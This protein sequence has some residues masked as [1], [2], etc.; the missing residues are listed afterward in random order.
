MQNSP[1]QDCLQHHPTS[2]NRIPQSQHQGLIRQ[3]RGG[4][5]VSPPVSREQLRPHRME[6]HGREHLPQE[7]SAPGQ[8]GEEALRQT[9]L[10]GPKHTH[11][12]LP[13]ARSE[14]QTEPCHGKDT[15]APIPDLQEDCSRRGSL[16]VTRSNCRVRCSPTELTQ[17]SPA[18]NERCS[19]QGFLAVGMHAGWNCSLHP[20]CTRCCPCSCSPAR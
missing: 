19:Q 20:L 11:L 3:Q 17:P 12:L 6:I 2:A 14:R 16:E 15:A 1:R 10:T 4:K 13:T 9:S 7:T 8:R 5:Q 18:S